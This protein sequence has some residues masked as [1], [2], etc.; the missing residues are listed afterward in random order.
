MFASG[1]DEDMGFFKDNNLD[2]LKDKN[3]D[4]KT[5]I[6]VFAS[7]DDEDMGGGSGDRVSK[8]SARPI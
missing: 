2:F 6:F 1:D 4:F 5:T 7:G 3:V 8:T